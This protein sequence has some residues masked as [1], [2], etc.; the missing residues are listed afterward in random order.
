[1][2]MSCSL[3]CLTGS[4]MILSTACHRNARQT[5]EPWQHHPDED[6]EQP[7][8]GHNSRALFG[9]GSFFLSF[10]SS[11]TLT[12][13]WH[14]LMSP[15]RLLRLEHTMREIASS[16]PPSVPQS[17]TCCR[18][19][20]CQ[21]LHHGLAQYLLISAL[22][23]QWTPNSRPPNSSLPEYC[24]HMPAFS[25]ISVPAICSGVLASPQVKPLQSLAVFAH[26][27]LSGLG[28]ECFSVIPPAIEGQMKI[29]LYRSLPWFTLVCRQWGGGRG[30]WNGTPPLM[31]G[32]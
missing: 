11:F 32:A 4:T 19:G 29:L 30:L 16:P 13:L 10:F 14:D 5:H 9:H 21:S 6:E 22:L 25:F 12:I 7:G 28:T 20:L 2:S 18:H 23:P 17:P 8:D 24:A 3:K 27:V 1:M 31:V 26:W 15:V